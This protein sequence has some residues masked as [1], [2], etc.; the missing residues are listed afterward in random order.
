MPA[1]RR[2][3]AILSL[4]CALAGPAGR[5]VAQ[6][7]PAAE[8]PVEAA[9]AGAPPADGPAEPATEMTPAQRAEY[10]AALREMARS[11]RAA[12]FDRMT[13]RIQ[14]K[15]AEKLDRI[16]MLLSLFALSGALLLLLPF[17]LRRK[18][19]DRM[20][21]LVRYSALAALLFY[22]AVNLFAVVLLLMRGT[23]TAFGEYTNPQIKL[24]AAT[25]DLIED[26]ADEMA[27]VGPLLIEPTLQSLSAEGDGTVLGIM[28][29]NVHK[30]RNDVSV[31]SSIA[32][33]VERLDWLFGMLPLVFVGLALFLFARVT[34]PTLTEIARLPERAAQGERGAVRHTLSLALR[35][36]WAETRVFFGVAGVLIALSVLASS[37]LGLV[38]EPAIEV[39]MAYLALAFLY[40][41]VDAAA[42]SFWILASLMG[43]L[44]FL[45]VNLAVILTILVL[46]KA[47][48]IFQQRYR[49][50]IPLRAHRRFWQW[51]ALGAVWIQVLPVLYVAVAVKAIGLFVE[52]SAD[53]MIDQTNPAASN[54]PFLLVSGP[55]L[56]LLGFA[57]IF[58]LGRGASALRFLARYRVDGQGYAAAA[59]AEHALTAAGARGV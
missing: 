41:Q 22:L 9:P 25:F 5:A 42:S 6:P 27:E 1:M 47:Q 48:K 26:K 14:E 36:V 45:L 23:Q 43:A 38:L 24:V 11:T 2:N 35:N 50:G 29:E 17:F 33:F 54:W 4:A 30:L 51:G 31:F 44:L 15:Q 37:L 12:M 21:V 56:F 3:L 32:R 8:A 52:A 20:G 55:L 58:W 16:S 13:A 57:L 59:A 40:I 49:A 18:Y 53:R 39:F 7:G 19:P 46:L 28:L 34:W 10:V